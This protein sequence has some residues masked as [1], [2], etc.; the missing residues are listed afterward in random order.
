MLFLFSKSSEFFTNCGLSTVSTI[1]WVFWNYYKVASNGNVGIKCFTMA[2]KLPAVRRD[3]MWFLISLVRVWV[4][5]LSLS[6]RTPPTRQFEVSHTQ[7]EFPMWSTFPPK[8][9]ICKKI[10]KKQGQP[11]LTRWS[12]VAFDEI[13]MRNFYSAVQDQ[14]P[15]Y[16]WIKSLLLILLS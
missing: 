3:L 8:I 16:H 9:S 15:D 6:L 13:Q 11:P 14:R 7:A 2:K 5:Q 12:E 10:F 1:I 4:T